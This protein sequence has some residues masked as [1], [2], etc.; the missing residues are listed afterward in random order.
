MTR[1][2]E[3]VHIAIV[4]RS[5]E[6]L[7]VRGRDEGRHG[8]GGEERSETHIGRLLDLA[9]PFRWSAL[10]CDAY[11]EYRWKESIHAGESV[12]R[13]AGVYEVCATRT[14]EWDDQHVALGV[15]AVAGL[16]WGKWNGSTGAVEFKWSREGVKESRGLGVWGLAPCYGVNVFV[17]YCFLPTI[18]C[19]SVI[20]REAVL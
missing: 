13:D 15:V 1:Q 10:R 6:G 18:V 5:P 17:F 19:L 3:R 11:T 12:A 8:E 2:T 20:T 7:R 16:V 9:G 14:R 4:M